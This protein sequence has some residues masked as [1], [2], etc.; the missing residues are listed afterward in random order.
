MDNIQFP[1]KDYRVLE[2]Y[3]LVGE[4]AHRV[5]NGADWAWV[6]HNIMNHIF[7]ESVKCMRIAKTEDQRARAQ[8]MLIAHDEVL[9]RLDYLIN[10]GDAARASL[11]ELQAATLDNEKEELNHA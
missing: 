1:D 7:E 9:S 2:N 5:K 3:S 11:V 4:Q 8:A 10:Q 6:K